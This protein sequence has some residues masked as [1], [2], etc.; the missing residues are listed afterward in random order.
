MSD[1]MISFAR[2]YAGDPGADAFGGGAGRLV[3]TGGTDVTTAPPGPGFKTEPSSGTRPAAGARVP[4]AGVP[5]AWAPGASPE[6][7]ARTVTRP[8]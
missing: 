1:G 2:V 6:G 3:L 5:C 7:T 4:G 8:C